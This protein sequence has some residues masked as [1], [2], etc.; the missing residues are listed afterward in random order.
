MVGVPPTALLLLYATTP[1]TERENVVILRPSG[2]IW[3]DAVSEDGNVIL[4]PEYATLLSR[5][6]ARKCWPK[7]TPVY[8]VDKFYD[9]FLSSSDRSGRFF[10]DNTHETEAETAE[11]LSCLVSTQ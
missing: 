5:N 10:Y 6:E 9:D 11:N 7:T 3:T 4:M 1:L 8:W 2:E